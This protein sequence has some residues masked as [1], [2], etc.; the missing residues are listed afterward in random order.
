MVR[1]DGLA[2]PCSPPSCMHVLRPGVGGGGG[3]SY[4]ASLSRSF[5]ICLTQKSMRP[6]MRIGRKAGVQHRVEA[7][8]PLLGDFTVQSALAAIGAWNSPRASDLFRATCI[9]S[10]YRCQRESLSRRIGFLTHAALAASLPRRAL[11]TFGADR[12]TED[13]GG[14]A[15]DHGLQC[16]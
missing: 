12:P 9:A 11:A 15:N 6:S 3:F 13:F 10:R 16:R 5:W 4:C 2:R 14:I 8:L 7:P 1:S